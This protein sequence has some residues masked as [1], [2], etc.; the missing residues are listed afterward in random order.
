MRH[1]K[2]VCIFIVMICIAFAMLYQVS[3]DKDE[4]NIKIQ[5]DNLIT[6]NDDWSCAVNGTDRG[7]VN[8]PI[9][10]T[11]MKENDKVVLTKTLNN[12]EK[13]QDTLLLRSVHN[14]VKVYLD[15]KLMYDYGK[16]TDNIFYNPGNAWNFI[17]LE[18][19]LNG[20][21][22][23]L[24]FCAPIQKYSGT[25]GEIY[26]GEEAALILEIV[27]SRSISI[28]MCIFIFSFG[29]FLLL[30]WIF[31]RKILEENNLLYLALFSILVAV[32][33]FGE[34][35]ML[36]F[37]YG[38]MQVISVLTFE[39][40]MIIPMPIL[41]HFASSKNKKVESVNLFMAAVCAIIFLINNIL[42]ITG[43][44]D[45]S[46]T[47]FLTHIMLLVGTIGA[48]LSTFA[49]KRELRENKQT[50]IIT[51][52][53]LGLVFFSITVIIDT[54]R[55]YLLDFGDSGS[56][57]RIGLVFYVF[58]LGIDYV[59]D[60]IA[61]VKLGKKAELYREMAYTDALTEVKS[62]VAYENRTKELDKI[63]KEVKPL[64]MTI[65]LNNLKY[66]NDT[67]GHESGDKYIKSNIDFLL[68]NIYGLGECYRVGG[69]EFNII[70]LEE[71]KEYF[72]YH[73][74]QIRKRLSAADLIVNFAFGVAEYDEN[75]DKTVSD[76]AGRADIKM[77]EMKSEMK[78]EAKKDIDKE[79]DKDMK[80]EIKKI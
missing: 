77:Y 66:I 42:Q 45:L 46:E 55:Y 62:R 3:L 23:T 28:L 56:F 60:I 61:A 1:K 74:E 17:R 57:T 9:K 41:L 68:S 10:L 76:I 51:T 4:K 13:N 44:K 34:T 7:T 32:W 54:I 37:V 5:N 39:S 43:I 49:G 26:L 40:L 25:I 14:N 52:S 79:I 73:I 16:E 6:L 47:V 33:S 53:M 35:K 72:N 70:V 18:D 58:T 48:F 71:N 19:S 20:K 38:N 12:I 64:V 31:L 27:Q 80:K 63:I 69:D 67:Y 22:L 2:H 65:D 50:G 15:E 36:Q 11:D 78:R 8:V 21:T 30:V 29:I 24:E 59:D 75:K